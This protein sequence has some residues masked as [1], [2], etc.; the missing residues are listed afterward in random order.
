MK[1]FHLILYIGL[2]LMLLAF[3]LNKFFWFMPD[4]DFTGY[5]EAEYLF[6]SLRFSGPEPTGKGYIMGLVGITEAVVGI[7]LILR[8]WIPF[9]LVVLVPISV[10]IVLFHAFVNLPNIGPAIL[11]AV[12]NAYL[13]Y[14]NWNSYKPLF[15]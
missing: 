3:G 6:K 10:N 5:P 11:V 14:K 1:I 13:I 8:K 12:A 9:A 2:G 15:S 4:F 7:L